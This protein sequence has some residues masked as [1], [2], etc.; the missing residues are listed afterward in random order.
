MLEILQRFLIVNTERWTATLTFAVCVQQKIVLPTGEKQLRNETTE[1]FTKHQIEFQTEFIR[2]TTI[3][4]LY[5]KDSEEIKLIYLRI[6]E[7]NRITSLLAI[8]ETNLF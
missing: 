1:H 7:T 8:Y 4:I 5:A 2:Y 3:F 6:Y